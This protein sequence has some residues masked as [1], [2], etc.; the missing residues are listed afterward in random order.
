MFNKT[1]RIQGEID[2]CKQHEIP[3][4]F[5]YDRLYKFATLCCETKEAHGISKK[6]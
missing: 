5:Y 2:L 3:S 4:L 1:L 6:L